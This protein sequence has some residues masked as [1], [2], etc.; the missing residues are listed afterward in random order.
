MEERVLKSLQ[1][2][3]SQGLCTKNGIDNLFKWKSN[4]NSPPSHAFPPAT[5]SQSLVLFTPLKIRIKRVVEERF[6]VSTVSERNES[7]GSWWGRFM[8][9]LMIKPLE[10]VGKLRKQNEWIGRHYMT[11]NLKMKSFEERLRQEG[12]KYLLCSFTLK[13]LDFCYK[14]RLP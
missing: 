10:F 13:L 2:E 6:S 11:W 5:F 7:L 14:V 3:N 8:A 9:S 4:S 12:S 1:P